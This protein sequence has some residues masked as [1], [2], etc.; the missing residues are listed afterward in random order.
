NR[1]IKFGAFL[2]KAL[3]LGYDTIATG[4]YGKILKDK[5]GI[6]HLHTADSAKDQSYVLYQMNQQVLSHLLLP[7]YGL[8]KDQ[9]RAYAQKA[10]IS[11]SDAP[12][13]QEICFIP[14]KDYAAFLNR[15]GVTVP[16]G[17]FVNLQGEIMG[18]HKG[19]IHYTVGQRKGLGAFGSPKYVLSLDPHTHQVVL[20]ENQDLF[21]NTLECYKVNWL[22]GVI[23]QDPITA[24]VKIRYSAP[25]APAVITPT[26]N[27]VYIVF[28]TPQRAI[29]PGQ[30][31]VFY[32]DN[33]LIGGGIISQN[34]EG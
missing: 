4:H 26:P 30:S 23:P 2:Q 28:K 15:M 14:D 1:A 10:G 18:P 21:G 6:Y 17:N 11:V 25:G 22:S 24:N 34:K 16:V 13:S 27:G 3:E 19:I 8:S 9:V 20:G 29:T 31:A 7:L 12:D 32:Q 33:E 5:D